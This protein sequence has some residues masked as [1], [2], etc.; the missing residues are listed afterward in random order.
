M[1]RASRRKQERGVVDVAPNG[2]LRFHMR[3]DMLERMMNLPANLKIASIGPADDVPP[4]E[5][6]IV[7][8]GQGLPP[9]EADKPLLFAA[10]CFGWNFE[11]LEE[12]EPAG[13]E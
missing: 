6:E 2:Q 13:V 11:P 5:C 10:T 4:G 7:V 8:A 3:Y 9:V 1:G 12:Y